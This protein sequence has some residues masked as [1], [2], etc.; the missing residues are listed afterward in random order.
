MAQ[1]H[2]KSNYR[3]KWGNN[4]FLSQHWHLYAEK[5]SV[6]GVKY[7]SDA[8]LN[9]PQKFVGQLFAKLG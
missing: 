1:K 9:L 7:I 3:K 6:H 5:T 8:S 4:K 2:N